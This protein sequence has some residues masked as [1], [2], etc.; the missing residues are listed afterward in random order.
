MEN[1]HY[2]MEIKKLNGHTFKYIYESRNG[3]SADHIVCLLS[4]SGFERI[5]N[6]YDIPC[7]GIKVN[8]ISGTR[9]HQIAK[10]KIFELFDKAVEA[11]YVD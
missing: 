5:L 3:S 11:I 4:N 9:E 1:N 8:Y 6:S 7:Q 10:K 2:Y